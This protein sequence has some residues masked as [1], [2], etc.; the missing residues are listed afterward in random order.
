MRKEK[1]EENGMKSCVSYAQ[2]SK[3]TTSNSPLY[4]KKIGL[5]TLQVK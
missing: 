2:I 5:D 1:R 3:Y 4:G